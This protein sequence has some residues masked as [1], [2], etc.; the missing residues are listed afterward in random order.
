MINCAN[1]ENAKVIY[2]LDTLG[3]P[4]H[5][6]RCSA[7]HWRNHK[8]GNERHYT[9]VGV[10]DMRPPAYHTCPDYVSMGEEIEGFLSTLPPDRASYRLFWLGDSTPHGCAVASTSTKGNE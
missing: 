3:R 2:K 10:R 8:T 7:G 1:C 9:L 4:I 6:V 5:K